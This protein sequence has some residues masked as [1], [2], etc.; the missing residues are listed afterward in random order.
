[1]VSQK[2]NPFPK[3]INENVAY[4]LRL[5]G[6]RDR[7]RIDETVERSLRGAALWDEVK[8]RLHD[9]ALGLSGGQQQ[10][11]VIARATAVEP[12][13]LLLD[14][15]ASALGPITR[16][17]CTW[18]SWSNT[19][20]PTPCSL[21]RRRNRRKITSPAVTAKRIR[22]REVKRLTGERRGYRQWTDTISVITSHSSSTKSSKTSAIKY[23]PWAGWSNSS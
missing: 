23:S 7:R 9:S 2:P 8:A 11:L 12:E 5:Q 16:R 20:T 13:V 4:G 19:K 18:V 17:S 10:R 22:S 14:E 15:P 6:M 21:I 1:M 3:S